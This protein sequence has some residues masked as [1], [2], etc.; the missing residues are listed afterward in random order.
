MIIVSIVAFALASLILLESFLR[1]SDFFSPIRTYFFFHSLS[2]GVA[3]LALDPR[4]TPFKPLTSL[5]YFGSAACFL[6]GAWSARLLAPKGDGIVRR[7]D[8]SRYNWRMH[9]GWA[10]FIFVVFVAGMTVAYLGTGQFPMLAEEKGRAI[11][12]FFDYKFSASVALSFGGVAMTLFF[13]YAFRPRKGSRLWNPGILMAAATLAI[14]MLALSRSG[15]VVFGCFAVVF[16]HYAFRRLSIPK[17]GLLF[18]VF[19]SFIIITGYMKT[20]DIRKTYQIEFSDVLALA[21]RIP[22]LY[23]AN[24][25]WNLD[26]ALN[27][28]AHMERHPTTYGF[29]TTSG[30][31]GLMS[32]PGGNLAAG[33]RE[34]TQIDDQFHERSIKSRGWNTVGYQWDLYK[35]FGLPGTLLGPFLIGLFFGFLY[36]RVTRTPTVLNV[37]T[38]S[39]LFFFLAGSV[40]GFLPENSIYV[41]GTIYV[42]LCC[43]LAH[44]TYPA[45]PG[46]TTST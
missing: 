27:P 14:F 26:H 12:A 44:R 34:N 5:V 17:L 38:Y 32:L 1:K 11:K 8:F 22:Y 42:A 31:L 7:V 28:P 36:L 29:T 21:M 35:D 15:I 10:T 33:I 37:A 4:M 9:L 25:Y 19:A 2:L 13:I 18:A 24:N 16:Y 3:F 30:L 43:Y 45:G 23:I 6:M 41:Y 40:F 20:S 39:F 46:I